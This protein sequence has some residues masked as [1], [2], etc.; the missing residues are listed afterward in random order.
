MADI[1]QVFLQA[2]ESDFASS[3]SERIECFTA[4]RD[5]NTFCPK[6]ERIV[7]F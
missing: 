3:D 1:F 7:N 5:L 6:I 2:D 4:M